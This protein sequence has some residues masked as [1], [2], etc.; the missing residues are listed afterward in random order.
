[1][2]DYGHRIIDISADCFLKVFYGFL[3]HILRGPADSCDR[4]QL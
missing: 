4:L 2:S 1:M 3:G